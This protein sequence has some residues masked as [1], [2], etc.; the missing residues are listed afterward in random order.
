MFDLVSPK[1][2]P[3]LN[4]ISGGTPEDPALNSLSEPCTAQRFEWLEVADPAWSTTL[5][6]SIAA[7]DTAV[8]TV[9]APGILVEGHIVQFATGEYAVVG[10]TTGANTVPLA[11]RGFAG[12]TAAIQSD[13]GV[14]TIVGR[15]HREGAVSP[16]DKVLYP[17]LP[18]NFCQ[19]FAAGI[20][21]SEI[22]QAIDRYGVD[23]AIEFETKNQMRQLLIGWNRQLYHDLRVLNASGVP[24]SMGGL[25]TYVPA[26]NVTNASAGALTTKMVGDLM[27]VIF[28]SAGRSNMPDTIV[29]GPWVKR[30]ISTLFSSIVGT[31]GTGPLTTERMEN[32]RSA[33]VVL[34]VINTDFGAIDVVVDQWCPAGELYLLKKDCLGIGPLKDKVLTREPMAKTGTSDQFMISGT[35]TFQMRQA[36]SHGRIHGISTTT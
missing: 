5:S 19:E 9:V 23:N 10:V 6:A 34:D 2:V 11:I 1:D 26:A 32:S 36:R 16:Q 31:I 3:L 13:A 29:C 20:I 33:G 8:M 28:E 4:L 35:Y 18:H 22:E 25:R 21:I 24:G 30:K 12:S 15:T 14:V 27:Q 7:V 17:T